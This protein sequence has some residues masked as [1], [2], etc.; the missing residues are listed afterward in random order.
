MALRTQSYTR[1]REML[2]L[3]ACPVC[4]YDYDE[5][6]DRHPHI[7]EHD[8]E[9]FGLAPLGETNEDAQGP[10]FTA[11]EDLPTLTEPDPDQNLGHVHSANQ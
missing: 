8:P 9:D 6:E 7:A 10:L 2:V 3:E 1:S 11:V 4:G 5:N